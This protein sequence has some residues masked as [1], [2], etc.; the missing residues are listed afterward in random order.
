MKKVIIMALLIVSCGLSAETQRDLGTAGVFDFLK[1][2]QVNNTTS[3]FKEA[4]GNQLK[5]GQSCE[6]VCLLEFRSCTS[7]AQGTGEWWYCELTFERC[8]VGCGY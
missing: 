2:S 7:S 8:M 4:K 5:S 3:I 6:H 1:T